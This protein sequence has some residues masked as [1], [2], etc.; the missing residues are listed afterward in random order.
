MVDSSIVREWFDKAD[1]DFEFARMNLEEKKTFFAQICFHFQQAAEKYLKA[2][3]I[4]HTL[5]FRKIHELPMLLKTCMVNDAS[6]N[7]LKDDCEYL[8][9]YYVETRYPVHWPTNFSDRET[10]KA[11][12]SASRIRS[13]SKEKLE[14]ILANSTG[15]DN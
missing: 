8:T 5:E 7:K 15:A 6:L 2:Y 12:R 13:L 1:E 10:Q 4:A 9:V 3:I 11:F 14:P